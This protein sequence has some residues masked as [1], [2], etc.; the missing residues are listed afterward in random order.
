MFCSE[1]DEYRDVMLIIMISFLAFLKMS[2][3]VVKYHFLSLY[4]PMFHQGSVLGPLLFS[5]HV[6]DVTMCAK[7]DTTRDTLYADYFNAL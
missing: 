6:D 3:M 1:S 7:S 2:S 4:F 5:T